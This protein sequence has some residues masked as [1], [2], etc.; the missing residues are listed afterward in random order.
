MRKVLFII[1]SD[2]R[3]SHRPAEALRI[4]AGSGAWGRAVVHVCLSGPA[5]RMLDE[6]LSEL[7]DED[8]IA[9]SLSLLRGSGSPV[10]VHTTVE[11]DLQAEGTERLDL[12]G[13]AEL[14]MRHDVVAR[15]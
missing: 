14:A 8:Q 4:A 1:S 15:F 5:T 11:T 9:S 7:R 6:N 10:Y 13:L 2:P 12:K 3:T